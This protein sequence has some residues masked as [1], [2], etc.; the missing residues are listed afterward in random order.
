MAQGG[1]LRGRG[2]RKRRGVPQRVSARW[3]AT[4]ASARPRARP[5]LA[6]ARRR[7][8]GGA[9]TCAGRDSPSVHVPGRGGNV[10]ARAA[11]MQGASLALGGRGRAHA[12][13]AGPVL[14][15]GPHSGW[16]GGGGGQKPV[17]PAPGSPDTH[18]WTRHEAGGRVTRHTHAPPPPETDRLTDGARGCYAE[19][20]P[21]T[22]HPK[23]AEALSWAARLSRPLLTASV[24]GD[25]LCL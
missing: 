7:P 23:V 11:K 17:R 12:R 14:G 6:S 25:A 15:V 8:R 21:W 13:L 24:L 9:S 3:T 19:A 20:Q 5:Y 4:H 18:T 1:L 22:S 10:G 2:E 16:G